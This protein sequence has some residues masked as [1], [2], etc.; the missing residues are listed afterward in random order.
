[1]V[2]ENTAV[3]SDDVFEQVCHMAD[4]AREDQRLLAK[5]TPAVKQS[6][7]NSIADALAVR[8]DRIAAANA[9]DMKAAKAEGMS[10]SLLDR[11][12]LDANRVAA[13]AQG[14]RNVA[15]LTDPIGEVVSG[16]NLDNG[17]RLN[18][19]R[20]PMGVVGMIY[21]ARPN[22]TMDVIS[23]CLKSGNAV[24]LRGGHAAFN[25][26]RTIVEIVQTALK[27]NGF[28][29][30]LVTTVDNFG[31]IGAQ[32]MM[33][34]RGHIDVLVPRGS[35]SLINFVSQ[36]ALVPVIETG[37]GN[38]HVYVDETADFGKAVD[39]II[40]AKTQRTGVCNAEEKLLVHS[41]IAQEFL[42][43]V[44]DELIAHNVELRC[45]DRAFAI[46]SAYVSEH[47][48]QIAGK[49]AAKP[50][51]VEA[52]DADWDTEYLD[53]ILGIKVVDSADEA[54]EHIN[55]HSTHHTEAIVSENYSAIESFTQKV[56]SAVV[57]VNASTRFTD[58]S[59]FGFGAEL[60]IST[61]KLHARGPMGLRALT[62]TKWVGFGTG[63]VRS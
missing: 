13:S 38:V 22:V 16:H 2:Q 47:K 3:N 9:Q 6:L 10:E 54:I 33:R 37:A 52:T 35:A 45:D 59:I 12:L 43:I 7:I 39:I 20:V 57:M 26:N 5:S 24:M 34:A 46:L 25:T 28:G 49:T 62:T 51:I 8:A 61:Q 18:E 56:D 42:P 63:Q 11:L 53:L 1:M 23:L 29:V 15:A 55:A 31:R 60:G 27:D 32:S 40:N 48:T 21:E 17:M 19:T 36:N 50:H 30:N 41:N 58:G 44:A 14:M 4:I